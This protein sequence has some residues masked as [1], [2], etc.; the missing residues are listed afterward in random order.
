MNVVVEAIRKKWD[1]S[2]P[3]KVGEEEV[4]FL[5]MELGRTSE[6]L[7]LA[8]QVNYTLDMLKRN[9]PGP[10]ETWPTRKTPML[11]EIV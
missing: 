10:P 9:L 11:K 5:G 8:T 3:Q 1:T 2:R 7:W 4:R 6:G